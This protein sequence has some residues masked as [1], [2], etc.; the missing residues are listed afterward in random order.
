MIRL[1]ARVN[2][3]I[4]PNLYSLICK[5]IFP[6][7]HFAVKS[8][9]RKFQLECGTGFCDTKEVTIASLT[10]VSYPA[11]SGRIHNLCPKKLGTSRSQVRLLPEFA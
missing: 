10:V 9:N 7:Q 11:I 4:D 8:A 1:L 2:D 3:L 5:T 6:Q